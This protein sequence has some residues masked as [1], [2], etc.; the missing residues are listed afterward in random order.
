MAH[1]ADLLIPVS[2]STLA[3]WPN[4]SVTGLPTPAGSE[5]A[6][7]IASP[8]MAAL[9]LDRPSLFARIRASVRDRLGG[10]APE[11][12]SPRCRA[13][14]AARRRPQTAALLTA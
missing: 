11:V 8:V 9:P 10:A 2:V 7:S 5:P 6:M 4:Q 14:M 3:L 12:G 13:A 1:T